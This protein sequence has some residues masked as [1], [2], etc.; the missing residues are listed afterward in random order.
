M[1]K[2]EEKVIPYTGVSQHVPAPDT[3]PALT[4][5]LN[6]PSWTPADRDD[7]LRAIG[8]FLKHLTR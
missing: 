2:Y 3:D 7:V 6:K 1:M 8:K 4:A 5:L